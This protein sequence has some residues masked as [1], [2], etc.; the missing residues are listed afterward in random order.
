MSQTELS[1]FKSFSRFLAYKSAEIIKQY[2]RTEISVESKADMSPVTIAD[3]KSEEV[4]REVIMKEFPDHGIL[5]EEFGIHNEKAEYQWVLI[6]SD[7]RSDSGNPQPNKDY[8]YESIK[9]RWIPICDII[10][11]CL[12]FIQRQIR[13][14]LIIYTCEHIISHH[15][16]QSKQHQRKYEYYADHQ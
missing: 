8:Q 15:R 2:F 11:Y 4:M 9:Y 6:F 16:N 1:D 7:G 10:H 5:G 12:A 13:N 14:D 3:K